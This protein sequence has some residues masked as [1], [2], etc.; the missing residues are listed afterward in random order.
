MNKNNEI[1]EFQPKLDASGFVKVGS[2]GLLNWQAVNELIANSIDSWISTG[3]KKNLHVDILL[4]N[5]PIRPEDGKLIITDNASGMTLDELQSSFNFFDSEK[6]DDK[7]KDSYLGVFGFGFKAATSKIGKKVTVFSA[8]SEKE[9]Y[10]VVADYEAMQEQ[11]TSFKLKVEIIKHDSQSKTIFNNSPVGTRI[12]VERLNSSF[13]PEK[14]EEMLPI[15]W[16][17][18][19]TNEDSKFAKKV[20]ITKDFNNKKGTVL[21]DTSQADIETIYPIKQE[22]QIGKRQNKS[23][24]TVSGFVGLRT[25]KNTLN[26]PTQGIHLYRRGQ[27]VEPYTHEFYKKGDKHNS[28]NSLVG[29]LD[30]GLDAS[31]TKSKFDKDTEEY[32]QVKTELFKILKPFAEEAKLM[33]IAA[34]QDKKTIDKAVAEY[35]KNVGLKLSKKQ[36]ELIAKGGSVS[37]K[38]SK[39]TGAGTKDTF[40][41]VPDETNHSVKFKMNSWNSFTIDTD[42]Y[43]IIFEKVADEAKDGKLYSTMP[44]QG[45]DIYVVYYGGHPQGQYLEKALDKQEKD[46]ISALLVRVIISESV[47]TFLRSQKFNASEIKECINKVMN[48]KLQKGK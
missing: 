43:Q 9:Y 48:Y 34:Q 17:K 1:I 3:P 25:R 14:L 5:N 16:K 26:M 4:D 19:I 20:K 29:E 6:K 45:S 42:K 7:N 41:D 15:S 47:E 28:Q 40:I 33:S 32:K 35:R 22:I 11:G 21:A 2:T 18:F 38:D 31:V 37:D 46:Y 23:T 12:I 27:L 30:I 13:P 44:P 39:E 36:A 24:I 8:N 10:K